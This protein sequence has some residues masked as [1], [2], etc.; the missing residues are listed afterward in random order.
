MQGK[1]GI[2]S[3][4]VLT[5]ALGLI[6]AVLITHQG[7]SCSE[8][9]PLFQSPEE[10]LLVDAEE[11]ASHWGVSVD[12]ALRVSELGN[13]I[14]EMQAELEEKEKETFAGLWTEHAPRFQVIVLFTRGGE[15]TIR[16]YAE[17]RGLLGVVEVRSAQRSLAELEAAQIEY[18]TI[19]QDVLGSAVSSSDI[20]VKE[21]SVE[22][23]V[24]DQTRLLEE[25]QSAHLRLPDFV[26]VI[27]IEQQ[28]GFEQVGAS[29]GAIFV[30]R[31][32]QE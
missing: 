11:Y 12:E 27:K 15:E 4:V 29:R 6:L 7:W 3:L 17:S 24:L 22:I 20:K 28:G 14:G 21:N 16:P 10:A 8:V 26:H 5:L 25:L 13:R 2:M 9:T 1:R 19:V 18:T 23:Y 30:S 32:M 31:G